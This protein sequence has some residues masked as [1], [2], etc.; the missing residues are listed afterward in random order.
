L[1]VRA[2][3]KKEV[4]RAKG[5]KV[6]EKEVSPAEALERGGGGTGKSLWIRG[7]GGI[8]KFR[9]DMWMG[10]EEKKEKH[11]KPTGR[12]VGREKEEGIQFKKGL[13]GDDQTRQEKKGSQKKN[14]INGGSGKKRNPKPENC[15]WEKTRSG[16]EKRAQGKRDG[17]EETGREKR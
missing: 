14:P 2:K 12:E 10:R 17:I 8:R 13:E 6:S 3:A 4:V 11:N 9:I 1:P 15:G 5:K 7:G 16:K